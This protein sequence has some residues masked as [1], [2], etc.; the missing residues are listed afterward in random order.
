MIGLTA[1]AQESERK[2]CQLAGM[3]DCLFKPLDLNS[4]FHLDLIRHAGR[5]RS[6]AIVSALLQD[7][8]RPT[9]LQIATSEDAT[10]AVSEHAQILALCEDRAFEAAAACLRRHIEHVGAS[11]IALYRGALAEA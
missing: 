3:D 7:C 4:R 2:L 8:E 1:N 11:L 10:R 6:L 9:R 5:P